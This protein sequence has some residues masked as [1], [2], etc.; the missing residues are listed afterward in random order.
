VC[1]WFCFAS[2]VLKCVLTTSSILRGH[3]VSYVVFVYLASHLCSPPGYIAS[4]RN[5][6][7]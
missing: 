1:G 2:D 7:C 4:V 6:S 3:G 5:C